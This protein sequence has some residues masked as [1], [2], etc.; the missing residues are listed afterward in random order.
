MFCYKIKSSESLKLLK[1]EN[2]K[3]VIG[4]FI[5]VSSQQPCFI[6]VTGAGKDSIK[7]KIIYDYISIFRLSME[8]ST[9]TYM[10]KISERR[11]S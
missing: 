11:S 5:R 3:T 1:T 7:L 9:K 6:N 2:S 8:R 10:K 4:H